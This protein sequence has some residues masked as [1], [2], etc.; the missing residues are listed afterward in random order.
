MTEKQ[1]VLCHKIADYYRTNHQVLK[2]I[3]EI[4]KL[5]KELVNFVNE[6]GDI[7]NIL[8]KLA[9]TC[10]MIEQMTYCFDTYNIDIPKIIDAKL[11]YQIERMR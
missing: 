5:Q 3:E 9:D 11:K 6:C 2:T 4:P 7:N 1:K 10:I 8:D